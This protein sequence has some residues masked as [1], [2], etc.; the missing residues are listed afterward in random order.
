MVQRQLKVKYKIQDLIEKNQKKNI[1]LQKK[2]SKIS[3][4]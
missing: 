2:D 1:F 4:I 3:M